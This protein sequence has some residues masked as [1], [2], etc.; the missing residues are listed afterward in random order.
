MMDTVHVTTLAN[1]VSVSFNF[2]LKLLWF[3]ASYFIFEMPVTI[4]NGVNFGTDFVYD[5]FNGNIRAVVVI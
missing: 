1:R 3:F 4:I 5:F 2:L